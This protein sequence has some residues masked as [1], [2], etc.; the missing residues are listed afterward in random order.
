M[1]TGG[2]TVMRLDHHATAGDP[3]EQL[4]ELGHIFTDTLLYG[5][6]MVYP[7]E[8]DLQR[9]LHEPLRH[10]TASADG[11]QSWGRRDQ[12]WQRAV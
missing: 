12:T 5:V 4:I 8:G 3:V 6:G 2:I 1:Q 7:V 11:E 10:W 9:I